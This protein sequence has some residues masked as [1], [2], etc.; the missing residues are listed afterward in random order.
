VRRLAAVGIAV[1][2]ALSLASH[3]S[4]LVT[5]PGPHPTRRSAT[6]APDSALSLLPASTL[7][8]K[9]LVVKTDSSMALKMP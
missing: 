8:P 5:E 4:E 7:S 2:L 1:P 3:A 6:A 9:M